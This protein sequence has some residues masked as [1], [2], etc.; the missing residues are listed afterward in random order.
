MATPG[1]VSMGQLANKAPLVLSSSFSMQAVPLAT[2]RMRPVQVGSLRFQSAALRVVNKW[3]Q[4]VVSIIFDFSSFRLIILLV[5]VC[6]FVTVHVRVCV[7]VFLLRQ[8]TL[9]AKTK[10]V[11]KR[12]NNNNYTHTKAFCYTHAHTRTHTRAGTHT[13]CVHIHFTCK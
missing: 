7:C 5:Y 8:R 12:S 11:N 13:E 4:L 10:K 6:Q 9:E 3:L 2:R 1:Y